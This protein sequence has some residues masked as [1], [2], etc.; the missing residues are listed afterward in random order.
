MKTAVYT[1][2]LTPSISRKGFAAFFEYYKIKCGE[3]NFAPGA[4]GVS[5]GAS[6]APGVVPC[7]LKRKTGYRKLPS[8]AAWTL[9]L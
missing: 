8:V 4:P 2:K 5:R 6:Q 9:R 1:K 3:I 7:A